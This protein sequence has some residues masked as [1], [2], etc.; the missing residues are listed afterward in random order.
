M[1]DNIHSKQNAVP[2]QIP[3][4]RILKQPSEMSD[5]AVSV[6]KQFDS[7][8]WYFHFLHA[9]FPSHFVPLPWQP[10]SSHL[11][12]SLR[13]KK[14][15]FNIAERRCFATEGFDPQDVIFHESSHFLVPISVI[16]L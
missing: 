15:A 12:L 6:E 9:Q 13:L 8:N 10:L 14:G 1:C 16:I 11:T 3:L 4:P 2:L 7:N 5:R